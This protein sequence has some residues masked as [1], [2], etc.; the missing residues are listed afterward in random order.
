ML[1]LVDLDIGVEPLPP[2]LL[3]ADD[4]V[5]VSDENAMPKKRFFV[6]IKI[7]LDFCLVFDLM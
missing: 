3:C 2:I 1:H 5:N 6:Y 7:N 4:V